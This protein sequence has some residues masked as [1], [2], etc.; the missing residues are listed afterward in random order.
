MN[1]HVLLDNCIP[2]LQIEVNLQKQRKIRPKI[3][4]YCSNIV[5]QFNDD[6]FRQ[7]FRMCPT[8]FENLCQM[9][10]PFIIPCIRGRP[11]LDFRMTVLLFLRFM[12]TQE[13]LISLS[14]LFN[15]SISSAHRII[16]RILS[17][18]IPAVSNQLIQWPDL[19]AQKK[20]ATY[21]QQASGFLPIVVGAI[22]SRE[23]PIQK[24]FE[25]AESYFNR[26]SFY[27]IKIQAICNQH[28]VF[29]DTFVG[30]PGRSHDGRTFQNS[31]VSHD[32]ERG[33]KLSDGMVILGDSAYPLKSYL[34]T[35]FKDRNNLS[36]Q[37]R[38][39]NKRLS[40]ARV[41]S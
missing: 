4:D 15:V 12:G 28:T 24:P 2:L 29:I 21:F 26:K 25:N 33:I 9:L 14:Q 36:P 13:T 3:K 38:I 39:Y 10:S 18:F 41:V 16:R 17:A 32:L 6:Q 37:Q 34:L 8:S 31:P 19:N 20:S 30:W 35:P 23:N 11:E 5:P 7:T 27:S 40:S 1:F 22:D